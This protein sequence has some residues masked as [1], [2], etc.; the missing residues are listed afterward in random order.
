MG[1]KSTTNLVTEFILLVTVVEWL[2]KLITANAVVNVKTFNLMY[3]R[4]Q[5]IA[6][7]SFRYRF[8]KRGADGC[9]FWRYIDQRSYKDRL[10]TDDEDPLAVRR[11]YAIGLHP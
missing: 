6:F 5:E 1:Y 3:R 10:T 2:L 11:I 4:R 9:M 7:N 8:D